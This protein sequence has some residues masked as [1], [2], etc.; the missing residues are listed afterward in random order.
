M[1]LFS[2]IAGWA[3]E[4]SYDTSSFPL[5]YNLVGTLLFNPTMI[6]FDNQGTL[7]VN[8]SVNS[9]STC[10]TFTAG[11]VFVLDMSANNAAA[12]DYFFN[13]GQAFYVGGSVGTGSF[14]ISYLYRKA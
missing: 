4:L 2:Q 5:T 6:I 12:K 1:S 13:V 14:K 3:D 9:T 10:K 11:E 7:P 8:L